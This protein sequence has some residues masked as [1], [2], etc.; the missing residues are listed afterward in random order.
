MNTDLR[1]ALIAKTAL[2]DSRITH[3]GLIKTAVDEA[4]NELHKG[5]NVGHR[6]PQVIA[7]RAVKI[8]KNM[9]KQFST[10]NVIRFAANTE[11][12]FIY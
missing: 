3:I 1:N 4:Y 8:F 11:I 9:L 7:T 2:R 6:H 10:Q 12:A 5:P